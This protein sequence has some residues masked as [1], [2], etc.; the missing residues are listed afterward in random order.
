MKV[1]AISAFA[2]PGVCGCCAACRRPSAP[3]ILRDGAGLDSFSCPAD[4]HVFFRKLGIMLVS[5]EVFNLGFAVLLGRVLE[6]PGPGN[7]GKHTGARGDDHGSPLGG[8]S[9]AP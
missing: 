4:V 7:T 3:Q 9:L 6:Q 8:L 2:K 5:C 1:L